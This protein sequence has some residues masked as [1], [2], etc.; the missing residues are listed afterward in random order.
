MLTKITIGLISLLPLRGH[1][2]L[3]QFLGALLFRFNNRNRHISKVN[4]DLCFSS[5][6]EIEKKSLLQKTLKENGKTL[7][8][9]FWL[10]RHPQ[11]VLNKLLGNIENKQLLENANQQTLGTI[12][13]TP[14]FGSWEFIGLLT[15]AHSNLLILYAPPKSDY[16][17]QLSCKGRMSTGG[18]VIST[19]SLNI[20]TLIKHIKSGGSVGILPDQVPDGNGG[21]YSKFFGRKCF[22]STLVCK[23]ANKLQCPVVFCYALR[24]QENPTFYDA[25]Y[26]QAP[27]DIYNENIATATDALN[28]SIEQF[29]NQSPEQYIWGYK[30]FKRPAPGDNYPY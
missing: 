18:K 5:L 28:Q 4:I 30:R 14:H 10:W 15:A 2:Y 25:Y 19:Q 8:E 17:D 16:I 6:T 12:F 23:L 27:K 1:H 26:Y 3:G 29:I 13:V 22:T 21:I 11:Q 9:C 20:K 7:I 24:S